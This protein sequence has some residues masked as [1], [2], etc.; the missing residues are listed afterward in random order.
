MIYC[1]KKEGYVDQLMTCVKKD[2]PYYKAERDSCNYKKRRLKMIKHINCDK[3]N[4]S[5]ITECICDTC[6]KYLDMYDIKLM[7]APIEL[8]YKDGV[9]YDFCNYT[10]LLKFIV[11][12]IKKQQPKGE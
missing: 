9:I 8:H 2:C 5:I 3:C 11:E 6:G 7:P 1:A 12:E 4:Q 10:C